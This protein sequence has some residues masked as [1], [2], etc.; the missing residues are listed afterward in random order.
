M[1][2]C[3]PRDLALPHSGSMQ[4]CVLAWD[5]EYPQS[6]SQLMGNGR[7]SSGGII[8]RYILYSYSEDLQQESIYWVFYLPCLAFSMSIPAYSRITFQINYLH[9][10]PGLKIC[11]LG[12]G[13]HP[14]NMQ[15]PWNAA[16]SI[17][18]RNAR[19]R[20]AGLP[21]IHIIWAVIKEAH[22]SAR[23]TCGGLKT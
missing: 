10:S 19:P 1:S 23:G 12:R 18:P 8:L 13:T 22:P 9:P 4:K 7:Q 16:T 6:N 5:N 14:T 3:R 17:T 2:L 15:P 20:R 21:S 11:S